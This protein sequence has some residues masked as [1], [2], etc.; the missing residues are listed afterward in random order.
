MIPRKY[1]KSINQF[2]KYGERKW[3]KKFHKNEISKIRQGQLFSWHRLLRIYQKFDTSGTF[4]V[5]FFKSFLL[6][7]KKVRKSQY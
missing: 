4:F 3:G 7:S 5:F 1:L 2:S 6:L